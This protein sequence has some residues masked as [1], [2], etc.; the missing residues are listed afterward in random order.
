MP[1]RQTVALQDT[2]GFTIFLQE[3]P[4]ADRVP[5]QCALW[6]QV[7]ERRRLVRR[8]VRARGHLRPSAPRKSYRGYGAELAD[9]DGYLLRLW[10]EAID[11]G[12]SERRKA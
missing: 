10:D 6:F 12:R 9:P 3:V 2:E 1:E 11:E 8:V 4:R 7:A 5:N